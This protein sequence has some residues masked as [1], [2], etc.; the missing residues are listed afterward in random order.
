M[1]YW[2]AVGG[3][4]YIFPNGKSRQL[5]NSRISKE[6]Q[7]KGILKKGFVIASLLAFAL[8]TVNCKED[9]DDNS[10]AL[11]ALLLLQETPIAGSSLC[12]G[13]GVAAPT[14]TLSGDITSAITVTGSAKLTGTVNVT[15]G[16]SLTISP[17][18]VIFA[19]R[20]SSLF[21]YENGTL[22]AVGTATKPICFTSSTAVGSRAPGDW[23]GIVVIGNGGTSRGGGTSNTEGTT[24]RTYPATQDSKANL[25]YV[26]VEFVGNEV[27]V[28]NELNGV[29]SYAVNKSNSSYDYVQIHRGLDDGFEWWGGDVG[30][31][32]LLVTGGMDDDFDMDEGFTGTLTNIIGVKYPNSCGGT[33][34]TDPHGFEMDGSHTNGVASTRYTNPTVTNFTTIGQDIAAGQG[35]RL[36]E[37]MTGSFSKGLVY[38][39]VTN[40]FVCTTNA[41][42]G[43]A[44]NPVAWSEVKGETGKTFTQ[45]VCTNLTDNTELTSLPIETL[46]NIETCGTGDTVPDFTSKAA[47]AT[48]GGAP[49]AGGKWWLSWAV[50]RS[51]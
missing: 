7:M 27:A 36:R 51:K 40:N 32:H 33:V 29:S 34:S 14:Q 28:G 2:K 8:T 38:N 5:T 1:R 22:S 24:P 50:F 23:G 19:E 35:M 42:G 31:T 18:S 39:Y 45:G 10:A 47:Y 3:E 17:G 46:G 49:V 20:G 44:T 30:G 26:I 12:D 4:N 25:K 15:N 6:D 16:G 48:L 9:K 13:V 37:G 21:I 11:L 43:A 41:G